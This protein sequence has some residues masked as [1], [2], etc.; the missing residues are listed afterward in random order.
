MDHKD[1]WVEL[2]SELSANPSMLAR[3]GVFETKIIRRFNE[4]PTNPQK[5]RPKQ[6]AYYLHEVYFI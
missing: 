4:L 2:Q 3:Q 5:H 1:F 6:Q